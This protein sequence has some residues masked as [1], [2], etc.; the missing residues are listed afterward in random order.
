M[1]ISLG[2]LKITMQ[3]SMLLMGRQNKKE[4]EVAMKKF[5][6]EIGDGALI[7]VLGILILTLLRIVFYYVNVL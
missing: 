2:S 5:L 4:K 3:Q 1:S 7:A 6:S